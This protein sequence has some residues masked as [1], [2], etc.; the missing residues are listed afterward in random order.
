[1]KLFSD[2]DL[3]HEID[4]IH[5]GTVEAGTSKMITIYLFNDSEADLTNLTFEFPALPEKSLEIVD[6]PVTLHPKETGK[7]ILK[8]SPT[9]KFKKP[10]QVPIVIN[11]EEIYL[12]EVAV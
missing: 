9:L 4:V 1:M 2:P 12:A 7:L 6:A 5:F 3:K 10:L 8:W 11:A